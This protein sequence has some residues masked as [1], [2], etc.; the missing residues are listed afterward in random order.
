MERAVRCHCIGFQK[1]M[2]MLAKLRER[3]KGW[4]TI[5]I[6]AVLGLPASALWVYQEFS[7]V[8]FTPLIPAKYLPASVAAM[9][10]L[11]VVLRII[12]TGPVGSKGDET[13]TAKTKA[14]D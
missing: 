9:S 11:G 6:N 7:A 13:P 10:I 4:K 8:D 14:G 2:T 12:T 3:L 1:D 5:V